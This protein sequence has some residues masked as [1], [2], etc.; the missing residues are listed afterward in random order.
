MVG[1]LSKVKGCK[2]QIRFLK[3]RLENMVLNLCLPHFNTSAHCNKL[4][5]DGYDVTNLVSADPALR[6][7]GFKL[8]YFLRPPVQVTL[9]FDFQVELCRVDVELWPWGMDRGQACKKLEISTSSDQLTSKTLSQGH[10]QG[11]QKEKKQGQNQKKQNLEKQQEHE[12]NSCR[13]NGHQWSLQAQQWVEHEPPQRGHMSQSQIKTESSY[14]EAEFKLVGRCEVREETHVSFRRSNFSPRPPFLSSPPPQPLNCRQEELWSR[15]LLSLGAVTQLRV[16]VPYGGAASALGL[17]ALTVWGQPARCCSGDEV[18]RIK[19]VH[20]TN[21]RRFQRPALFT[22]TVSLTK[23]PSP[24]P[25]ALSNLSI[26]EEFLDPITQEIMMLPMLLPSG[27][28]VDNSTLEEHQKREATW[29][30]APNDPFT[31]VSF[32]S[33]SQP[34]PNPQLKSRIDL[35]LLQRGMMVK[36]GMLGRQGKG[37]NPQASRLIASKMDGE[38]QVSSYH[39][40]NSVSITGVSC[41]ENSNG[42]K[43]QEETGSGH[44]SE[45]GKYTC[46]FQRLTTEN[47]LEFGSKRKQ[48]LSGISKKPT[49][50][51]TSEKQLLPQAKKTRNDTVSSCSSH[52]Q[53]LSASL[54]EALF[55][56]LQGRPSFTTNLPRQKPETSD[57]DAPRS[58]LQSQTA[59]AP[60]MQRGDK[61]CSA[62]SCSVS[63]YSKSAS[64][65]YR[66]S[67]DH[68]LCGTCLRRKSQPLN[69]VTGS[70]ANHITCPSCLNST[71]RSD[72]IRVHH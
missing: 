57:S 53:R 34:L 22:S 19:R 68:L 31:G 72:I 8:E 37:E 25:A 40:K 45:N 64:S 10:K 9:K 48:D 23:A 56:A 43:T 27:V 41:K 21:E 11:Q 17:K 65:I 30:R 16:T 15:G 20:K 14:P 1:Q 55:S 67:C 70:T 59:G 12:S 71:Q 66:L 32:T 29:G 69:S 4:C 33:T 38:S 61:T 18:E 6:R 51:L 2:L 24:A 7:R 42:N 5:A 46:S 54:D 13:S 52:E 39:N 62:C 28:S 58:L 49:E 44:L 35:F 50:E 47:N 3:S 60:S 63:V 26:P 36:D